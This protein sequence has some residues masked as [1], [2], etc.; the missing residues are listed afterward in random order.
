[1]NY[2]NDNLNPTS[3]YWNL[4]NLSNDGSYNTPFGDL[5]YCKNKYLTSMLNGK[6]SIDASF[7]SLNQNIKDFNTF[8]LQFSNYPQ[9]NNINSS[10]P[11]SVLTGENKTTCI[12]YLTDISSTT[13]DISNA[14]AFQ[15]NSLNLL[16]TDKRCNTADYDDLQKQYQ[17]MTKKRED[18]DTIINQYNKKN[19]NSLV[20][21]NLQ[22]TDVL[23]YTSVLWIVL[24]TSAI[25]LSFRYLND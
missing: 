1:M 5:D 21:T 2:N 18:L 14:L 8:T 19:T 24:G 23:I 6:K 16:K 11:C 9:Y 20:H 10:D 3:G 17:A 7:V 4:Y 15:D 25:Y 13:I 22:E 12:K